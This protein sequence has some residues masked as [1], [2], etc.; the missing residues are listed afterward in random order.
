MRL[1]LSCLLVGLLSLGAHAQLREL[2]EKGTSAWEAQRY[3][4]AIEW[5][6]QAAAERPDS[7]LVWNALAEAYDAADRLD[8]AL[9]AYRRALPLTPEPWKIWLAMARLSLDQG[10]WQT[11]RALADQVLAERPRN[12]Q[13]HL[14][15]AGALQEAGDTSGAQAEYALLLHE[16][17]ENLAARLGRVR[18]WLDEQRWD[19]AQAD[20]QVLT[21]LDSGNLVVRSLA[22]QH[23]ELS[24]EFPDREA[25][26][27]GY[28]QLLTIQP[29][30]AEAMLALGRLLHQQG[31]DREAGVWL[32]KAARL[33]PSRS[34]AGLA[35]RA[36]RREHAT[37][38][39]VG[40]LQYRDGDSNRVD[41]VGAGVSFDLEPQTRMGVDWETVR[42]NQ[43]STGLAGSA[44]RE[45]IWVATRPSRQVAFS[46]RLGTV[47]LNPPGTFAVGSAAVILTP[48]EL[49]TIRLVVNR[50]QMAQTAQLI[51]NQIGYWNYGAEVEQRLPESNLLRLGYVR[52]AFSDDNRRDAYGLAFVHRI[53]V[54]EAVLE[55]GLSHRF[56]ANSRPVYS[57]YFNPARY[58][59]SE[60]TF[61]LRNP[62]VLEGL[63]YSVEMGAGYQQIEST[64]TGF[65]YRV[66]ARL[67][68]RLEDFDV[69]L[70]HR[71]SN[72][73][74]SSV[75]GFRYQETT[76]QLNF[77]F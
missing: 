37:R 19:E 58:H 72:A 68:Y 25:L 12:L 31:L 47:S 76:L 65:V 34:R 23:Q 43:V 46:T 57:G 3:E 9:E 70:G 45:Q 42:A 51:R 29:D 49:T 67:G 69:L 16:D 75:S 41:T 50:E 36:Y 39:S 14:I 26:E 1:L 64:P 21:K 32:D 5:F 44:H 55:L 53:T 15:R 28:R 27:A 18:L 73:A 2:V 48:S 56:Q 4:E 22:L 35:Y 10:D 8:E 38:L 63:L 66:G 33:T 20:I 54:P 60:L 62:D 59:I 74:I 11:A 17:P 52:S 61:E 6:R 24:E 13:A 77:Q 30:F 7:F 71:T 40:G